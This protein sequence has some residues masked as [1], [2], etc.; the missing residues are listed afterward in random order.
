MLGKITPP[1]LIRNLNFSGNFQKLSKSTQHKKRKFV[2]RCRI[3]VR[4]GDGGLGC[5]SFVRTLSGFGGPDG[6]N[7]GAGGDVYIKAVVAQQDLQF[8]SYSFV[9][10]RGTNGSSA[11][12]HGRKGEDLIINVPVGTMVREILP[13]ESLPMAQRPLRPLIDMIDTEQPYLVARGGLG[14][15]GNRVFRNTDRRT[16]RVSSSG[17]SGEEKILDLEL[18]TI[19]DV[20]LVGYPNAGKSSFLHRVSAATPKIAAYPF[21][22]LHPYVGV[23]PIPGGLAE[24][25]TLTIAD[26]PGLIDGAHL[27]R[28]L[29]HHFL[30]HIERT[31]VLLYVL[32]I[33]GSE[34]RDPIDDFAS[35][36]R[37]LEHY[38]PGLT[39]RPSAVLANKIDLKPRIAQKNIERLR[40]VTHLPIFSG[41]M[42]RNTNVAHVIDALWRLNMQAQQQA[43][44]QDNS[45]HDVAQQ[46]H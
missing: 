26:L 20:G 14:G 23:V 29:G 24:Q 41:S 1:K 32:D 6:G 17:E 43:I 31:K 46:N 4:G 5:S 9:A 21:T 16:P 13:D 8:P 35:L 15:Y 10:P 25:S 7:G 38:A 19:A 11:L 42:V 40:F 36:Q 28:G 39:T 22:T 2:D 45:D 18:K 12:C 44:D 3:K 33:A 27:N 30:R 34:G 37:E